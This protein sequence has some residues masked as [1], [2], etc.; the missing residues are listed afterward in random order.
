MDE[1]CLGW[2]GSCPRGLTGETRPARWATACPEEALKRQLE[3]CLCP[4][5]GQCISGSSQQEVLSEGKRRLTLNYNSTSHVS[6]FLSLTSL[7]FSSSQSIPAGDYPPRGSRD[8]IEVEKLEK[9][10]EALQASRR[11]ESLKY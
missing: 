8:K 7:P 9:K 11:R 10:L 6:L 1:A 5:E 4:G 3:K 2:L